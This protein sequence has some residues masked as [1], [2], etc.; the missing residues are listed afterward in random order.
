MHHDQPVFV[1]SVIAIDPSA[2]IEAEVFVE[3]HGGVVGRVDGQEHR[4]VGLFEAGS[5]Q[6]TSD[7]G[8]PAVGVDHDLVQTEFL[9]VGGKHHQCSGDVSRLRKGFRACRPSGDQQGGHVTPDSPDVLPVGNEQVG[10][11]WPGD[12]VEGRDVEVVA[13]G[14]RFNGAGHDEFLGSRSAVCFERRIGVVQRQVK[15]PANLH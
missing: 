12:T 1:G 11:H 7:S 6:F 4:R 5:H 2:D 10:G 3:S 14:G 13:V 15:W 8:S 9:G